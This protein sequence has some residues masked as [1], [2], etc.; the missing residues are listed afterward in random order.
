MVWLRTG[1]NGQYN[2]YFS[3]RAG[4]NLSALVRANPDNG[5]TTA[6]PYGPVGYM[7]TG[8]PGGLKINSLPGT[9]IAEGQSFKITDLA[10]R[11]ITFVFHNTANPPLPPPPAGAAYIN[12]ASG[13]TAD[14]VGSNM[15]F[16]ISNAFA[17][18]AS[19]Q[20][21]AKL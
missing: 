8:V 17:S 4:N 3:I 14:A 11:T 21:A 13:D 15:S 12:F 1:D 7:D 19:G 16:V 2:L 5:D 18:L 6:A 9:N 20:S 10:G